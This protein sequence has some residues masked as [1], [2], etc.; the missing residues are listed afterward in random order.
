MAS[1]GPQSPCDPNGTRVL[2]GSNTTRSLRWMLI[3]SLDPRLSGR[4][5]ASHLLVS[6]GTRRYDILAR[7]GPSAPFHLSGGRD[8]S[9][10]LSPS[11]Q[12]CGDIPTRGRSRGRTTETFRLSVTGLA[13]DSHQRPTASPEELNPLQQLFILGTL[14]PAARRTHRNQP[15][16]GFW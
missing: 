13:V 1:N 6:S 15:V 10:S 11:L 4:L 8:R 7:R 12:C 3:A 2:F 9:G 14:R 16:R 5:C